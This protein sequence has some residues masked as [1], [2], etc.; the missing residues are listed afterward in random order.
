MVE[1][2]PAKLPLLYHA[3]MACSLAVRIAAA[4]GNVPIELA[5]V[6]L[7]THRL[8]DGS[9]YYA[10]NPLG[11][12]STLQLPDGNLLFEN[13][14]CLLWV[15]NQS[16][17]INFRRAPEHPDS[18]FLI[19]WLSFISTQ[20]HQQIF[21]IVFYDEADAAVKDNIRALAPDRLAL[22]DGHLQ[23]RKWLLGGEFSAAD[24]YL[25]WALSLTDKAGLDIA[26]HHS[27]TRYW[28]QA[29]ADSDIAEIIA[30]DTLRKAQKS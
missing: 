13:I 25:V 16:P 15:Q 12:V 14:A 30:D 6:D 3:P 8:A 11:Q 1:D 19:R 20:L 18:I 26:P 17:N 2:S 27:L 10:I 4:K 22:L 7:N 29:L 24:A 28:E 23:N 5:I 21:R 9:D